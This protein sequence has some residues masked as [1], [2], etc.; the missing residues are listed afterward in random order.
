M[1]DKYLSF[2]NSIRKLPYGLF[3]K[4]D[5]VLAL[6]ISPIDFYNYR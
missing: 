5:I 6:V 1:F 2:K 4:N 3:T